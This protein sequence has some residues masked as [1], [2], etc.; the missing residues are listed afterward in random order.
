[1]IKSVIQSDFTYFRITSD[2]LCITYILFLLF[3]F[4][5]EIREEVNF[6]ESL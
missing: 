2:M 6:G 5:E 1:M 3:F 4:K